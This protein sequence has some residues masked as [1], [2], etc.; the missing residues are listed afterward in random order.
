MRRTHLSVATP[1]AAGRR[2]AGGGL[3]ATQDGLIA[4][5][6][7]PAWMFTASAGDMIA[8][9]VVDATLQVP[10][11]EDWLATPDD[12]NTGA[13]DFGCCA[14]NS[15]DGDGVS[16]SPTAWPLTHTGGKSICAVARC[17]G[18]NCASENAVMASLTVSSAQIELPG[19]YSTTVAVK[20]LKTTPR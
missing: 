2:A 6:D 4:S 7:S 12:T 3:G 11:G 13:D 8:G 9:G 14:F 18:G 10:Q 17:I 16:D 19:V 15:P 5:G 1:T 20:R